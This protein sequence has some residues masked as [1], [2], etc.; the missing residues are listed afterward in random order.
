MQLGTQRAEDWGS[1]SSLAWGQ[2][3]RRLKEL[4]QGQEDQGHGSEAYRLKLRSLEK[5]L[6]AKRVEA[7][8][9]PAAQG[10][11]RLA[12]VRDLAS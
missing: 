6:N 8:L 7:K 1:E 11:Q 3:P 9:G 2:G 10:K 12:S 5:G 4:N